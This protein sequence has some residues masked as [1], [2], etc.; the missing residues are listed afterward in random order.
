MARAAASA[1]AC[2]CCTGD[3]VLGTMT[4][5]ARVDGSEGSGW[6]TCTRGVGKSRSTP[7]VAYVSTI[8][9]PAFAVASL[10]LPK[11]N[12]ANGSGRSDTKRACCS[13]IDEDDVGRFDVSVNQLV[14]V[15]IF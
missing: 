10:Y 7:F 6:I 4:C 13:A 3:G 15:E 11:L 8:T 1:T 14:S 9:S 12:P 5:V 2:S